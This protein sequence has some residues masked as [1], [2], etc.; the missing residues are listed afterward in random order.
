MSQINTLGHLTVKCFVAKIFTF[1]AN[2][3]Q[4]EI[5]LIALS[6]LISALEKASWL[7]SGMYGCLVLE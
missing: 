1:T 4:L 5:S 7:I 6:V 3:Y 2:Q